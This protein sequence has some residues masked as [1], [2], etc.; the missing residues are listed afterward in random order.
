MVLRLTCMHMGLLVVIRKTAII[1]NRSLFCITY[2]ANV[3]PTRLN[4]KKIRTIVSY[5][6]S[7]VLCFYSRCMLLKCM[8]FLSLDCKCIWCMRFHINL[9]YIES[10]KYCWINI[11][12]SY[13]IN[14]FLIIKSR[15]FILLTIINLLLFNV[16]N[17][18]YV[19]KQEIV[20]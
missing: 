7:D 14:W 17:A 6:D 4:V 9:K 18:N 1:K 2:W 10:W 20:M 16:N 12:V 19:V 5:H 3:E 15:S 11:M 8:K 13:A